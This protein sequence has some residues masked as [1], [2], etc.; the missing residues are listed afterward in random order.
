MIVKM[1]KYTF[2]VYHCQYAKFLDEL[3]EIGVLHLTEKPE[4]IEENDS[5]RE[6]MQ[7]AAK[8]KSVL[9]KLK[10]FRP[11]K[12]VLLPADSSKNGLQL[13][14]NVENIFREKDS[15]ISK[16]ALLDKE[17]ERM[18]VWGHFN[19]ER[20]EQMKQAGYEI[21]FFSCSTKKFDQEWE[22]LY[23]A[24]EI[25]T[26]GS[27]IY[28]TTVTKVGNAIEIN[29]DPVKLS[30]QTAEEITTEIIQLRANL[31]I[32]NKKIETLSV[33]DYN[34]LKAAEAEIMTAITIDKAVLNTYSEVDDKVRILEG[35]C[36]VD[37]EDALNEYLNSSD[38]YF[39]TA[40]PQLDEKVPIKLKNN[41]FS[42]LFEF[43][44]ELYDLPNYFERDLTAYFA[45]FYV[46]FFGL[47]LGDA[48]YGLLI[49]SIGL[50]ARARIKE[51]TMRSVMS[52]LAVLG[53]GAVIMGII[54]G[55]FFGVSLSNPQTV[56]LN[57]IQKVMLDSDLLFI[58]ALMFGVIQ[59][60]FGMCIKFAGEV[61]RKGFL[62]S[63]ATLG[64]LI[65]IIGGGGSVGLSK[66]GIISP[67]LSKWILIASISI[68]GLFVFILNNFKRNP[69][70]NI[71]AGVWDTYNMVTG[72]LGDVLSYI[73]LFALGLSGGVMGTVFNSLAFSLGGGIDIP[74]ARELVVLIILVFGHCINIFMAVLGSLV[75]PVRL[76]FVEFYKNAGFEG[77]GKKYRPFANYKEEVKIL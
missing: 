26:V 73:R 11:E 40:E 49:L 21:R 64:W 20:F 45:P 33:E 76:T 67:E 61:S 1:K 39:E 57:P 66:F 48:G 43:I 19:P 34:T 54:S 25:D 38:I 63:L 75:H 62:N 55:A 68:G 27:T 59:I 6:K 65:A 60:I 18:E 46:I 23:N 51:P 32:T 29:A 74:V 41:K 7:I 72:I 15:I 53:G 35:F 36:P 52:L 42:K 5:L 4:G 30:E 28:F 9:K 70:L 14:E 44:G 8:I 10:F 56:W 69:I 16:V 24:F 13:L 3:R 77:G 17:R 50:I 31:E 2:L 71:G 22:V 58:N 12:A 37:S 47:C